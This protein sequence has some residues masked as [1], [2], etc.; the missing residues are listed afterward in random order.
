MQF[1]R[2]HVHVWNYFFKL[3]QAHKLIKSGNFHGCF[4]YGTIIWTWITYKKISCYI[5][6]SAGRWFIVD[7]VKLSWDYIKHF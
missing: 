5:H 4:E 2:Y 1:Q 7:D 6:D 3:T